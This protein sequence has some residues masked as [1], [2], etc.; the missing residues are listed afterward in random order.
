[1]KKWI[2]WMKFVI[3]FKDNE[4]INNHKV[5]DEGNLVGFSDNEPTIA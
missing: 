2:K 5:I 4:M 1:M 3:G